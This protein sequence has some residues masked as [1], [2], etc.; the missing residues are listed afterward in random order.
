MRSVVVPAAAPRRLADW[1]IFSDV[2]A[3]APAAAST[4]DGFAA[5]R[6]AAAG[7]ETPPVRSRKRR[8]RREDEKL[9]PE[10]AALH[11]E[12][13]AEAEAA[14]AAAADPLAGL[15]P[16]PAEPGLVRVYTDGS[17]VGNGKAGCFAGIGVFYG[18]DDPRNV[19]WVLTKGKAS[20][21]NAELQ[22]LFLATEEGDRMLREGEAERVHIHTDSQYGISCAT[23]WYA[24]WVRNGWVNSS[25]RPVAHREWIEP[26]ANR[27]ALWKGRLVLVKIKA[28]VGLWGNEQADELARSAAE[29]AR[30]AWLQRRADPDHPDAPHAV[31]YAEPSARPRVKRE[32]QHKRVQLG[33]M[34]VDIVDRPAPPA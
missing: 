32:F 31:V 17:C 7:A 5:E 6:K 30:K 20:N 33:G 1:Q 2:P 29:R 14:E 18:P 11:A 13:D 22:A 23:T 16:P 12:A 15:A 25:G 10:L 3:P 9:D 8:P 24:G 28:H 4:E 34:W 27:L 19:S 21:Q 26:I